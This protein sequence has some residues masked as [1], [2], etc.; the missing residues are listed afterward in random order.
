MDYYLPSFYKHLHR[1][2]SINKLLYVMHTINLVASVLNRTR[3]VHASIN[4]LVEL[5]EILLSSGTEI[6]SIIDQRFAMLNNLRR[7]CLAKN[8]RSSRQLCSV[9]TAAADCESEHERINHGIRICRTRNH[10]HPQKCWRLRL[11]E[12]VVKSA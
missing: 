4:F 12:E 10:M 7:R 5:R 1:L 8:L 2:V 9:L 6:R 11:N 3:K